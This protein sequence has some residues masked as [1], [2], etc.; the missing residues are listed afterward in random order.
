LD[1]LKI[2]R[3][4]VIEFDTS[5]NSASLVSAIIAMGKSLKL[6]LVAEGVDTV[7]QFL[8]LR[9]RQVDIIQ[10]YLFSKPL[11]AAEFEKVMS[12]NPFPAQIRDMLSA[13]SAPAQGSQALDEDAGQFAAES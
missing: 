13:D 6:S 12:D 2:D 1:E 9:E 7:E 8:F 10:G 5:E 11:P 3:S 4:F